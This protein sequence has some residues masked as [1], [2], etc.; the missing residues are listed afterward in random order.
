MNSNQQ[1]EDSNAPFQ[2]QKG[3]PSWWLYLLGG[4]VLLFLLQK[5]GCGPVKTHE[6]MQWIDR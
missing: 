3:R 1:I 2:S 4:I 6:E 5:I